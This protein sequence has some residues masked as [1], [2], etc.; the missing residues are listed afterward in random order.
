MISFFKSILADK[1][2]QRRHN[3]PLAL[4]GYTS[5]QKATGERGKSKCLFKVFAFA[6][7]SNASIGF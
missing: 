3:M 7:N 6:L 1:A 2:N 5:D 4:N